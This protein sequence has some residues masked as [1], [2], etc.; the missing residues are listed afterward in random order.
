MKNSKS[1]KLILTIVVITS[2]FLSMMAGCSSKPSDQ[3]STL[4]TDGTTQTSQSNTADTTSTAA[5][6]ADTTQAPQSN[7]VPK[8]GDT[9][10]DGIPDAIEKTYGTNPYSADTDGDGINDKEDNNPVFTDNPIQDSSTVATALV[11]KDARV[12][13]NATADHLE[14]TLENTGSSD[15][16]DPDIYYTITDKK[17]NSQEAYYQK[18]NGLTIK[19]GE[20]AT[21]HF[22]NLL[23]EQGHYYGNPNGLYGTSAN[24]LTFNI[25]VHNTGFKPLMITL[26]KDAGVEVAD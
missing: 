19:A 25:Q 15:I 12:E 10:G 9:D 26:E 7:A 18:L 23:T 22:D 11:V 8:D 16:V 6:T 4:P 5:A 2:V 13:D 1:I 20:S 17:T 14:I 24:G 3:I 21:I